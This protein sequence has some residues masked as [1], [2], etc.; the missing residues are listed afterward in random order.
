MGEILGVRLRLIACAVE[1]RCLLIAD[2][3]SEA[4]RALNWCAMSSRRV[5]DNA[6]YLRDYARGLG[7]ERRG[8]EVRPYIGS[9]LAGVEGDEG[10]ADGLG[11]FA[12]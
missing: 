3:N 6:P 1:R 10:G 7:S 5:R 2:G 8:Q 9:A 11:E 12:E 4:W